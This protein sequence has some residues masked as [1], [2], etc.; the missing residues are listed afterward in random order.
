MSAVSLADTYSEVSG[1]S[2]ITAV[3][4]FKKSRLPRH[5]EIYAEG[6]H[7]LEVEIDKWSIKETPNGV[8]FFGTPCKGKIKFPRIFFYIAD[9]SYE[10]VDIQPL[11]QYSLGVEK[12]KWR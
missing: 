11:P 9:K 5:V 1:M 12:I 7:F 10:G 3:L 4:V 2:I 6:R 8:S